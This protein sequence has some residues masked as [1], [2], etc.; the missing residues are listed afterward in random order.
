MKIKQS[1][2]TRFFKFETAERLRDTGNYILK[3]I[4]SLG[5]H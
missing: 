1:R 3:A 2:F 5:S 4:S